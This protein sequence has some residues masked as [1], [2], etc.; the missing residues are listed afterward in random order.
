M[1]ILRA[2]KSKTEN[3]SNQCSCNALIKCNKIKCTIMVLVVEKINLIGFRRE[4]DSLAY[5]KWLYQKL[6]VQGEDNLLIIEN[7]IDSVI[8]C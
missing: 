1:N 2:T 6:N 4:G 7:M 8:F 5:F 3:S